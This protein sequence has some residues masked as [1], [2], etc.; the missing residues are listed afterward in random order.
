MRTLALVI[1]A[2][3]AVLAL[4]VDTANAAPPS[5]PSRP[6]DIEMRQVPIGDVFHLLAEVSKRPVVLDPCVKGAVDLNLKNA[7]VP[8]VFDVLAL[9]LRLRYVE[10][11]GA[12]LVSCLGPNE[13]ALGPDP[14]LEKR[15]SVAVSAAPARAVLAQVAEAAGLAGVDYRAAEEPRVTITL[16]NVRLGT[17]LG[18]VADETGLRLSV[19]GARLVAAAR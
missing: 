14:Q 3:V 8:V 16:E 2:A 7:P 18:A 15:V 17:L 5:L 10:R 4:P 11:D 6:L 12:I 1:A 9:K 13:P 19:E